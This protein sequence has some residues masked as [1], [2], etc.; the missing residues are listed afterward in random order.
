MRIC[1]IGLPSSGKTTVFRALTGLAADEV[2]PD[3]QGQ[4]IRAVPVPDPRVDLLSG[5]YHP[6]KTTYAQIEYV[7][8]GGAA[9]I[10]AGAGELGARFLTAVRPAAM[11]V[12]VIDAFSGTAAIDAAVAE[13]VDTVDTELTLA[14][15]Q[16]AEKR[17]V[18]LRKE[19]AKSGPAVEEQRLLEELLPLLESGRPLRLRP[20]IAGAPLLRG[21]TF[22]SAKPIL[23][24]VN[25]AE[26]QTAWTPAALPAAVVEARAGAS[27]QFIALSAPIEADIAGLPPDEAAA[28]LA[29]YGI[30]SPV[31]SRVLQLSY[32]LLGLMSFFTVGEDEVRAW[33]IPK[34]ATAQEAAGVIHTDIARGFIRAEVVDYEST[35]AAGGFEAA[36]KRGKQRLEGKTYVMADG[37]CVNFRF[38]L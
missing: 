26:D 15:L 24:L 11:L 4:V 21:F 34:G 16:V 12:H 6:K 8:L 37:D 10:K 14:D 35:K 31:R 18:R 1:I 22:L 23:T 13:A 5:L 2:V 20:D 32:D 38:N 17:L 3:A 36:K 33:T 9:G 30:A 28:F 29:D 25:T 19:A 7:D 27:G